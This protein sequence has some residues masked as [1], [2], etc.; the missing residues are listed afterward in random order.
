MVFKFI[1]HASYSQ[2]ATDVEE[3][4]KEK[5]QYEPND[6]RALLNIKQSNKIKE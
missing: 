1:K 4:G 6:L 3:K 2:Q 5:L